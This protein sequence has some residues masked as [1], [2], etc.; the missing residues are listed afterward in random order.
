M[1]LPCVLAS[2]GALY[3]LNSCQERFCINLTMRRPLKLYYESK[4][5]TKSTTIL[6]LYKTRLCPVTRYRKTKSTWVYVLVV[7][8]IKASANK[9]AILVFAF[10]TPQH[11][12]YFGWPFAVKF[13]SRVY[14]PQDVRDEKVSS[15]LEHWEHEEIK[16]LVQSKIRWIHGKSMECHPDKTLMKNSISIPPRFCRVLHVPSVLGPNWL[17]HLGRLGG[18]S[19]LRVD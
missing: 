5:T 2:D 19:R 15:A 18:D 9:N 13:F 8:A 7:M 6:H 17:F 4:D 11:F 16:T 1:V 10:Q 14:H 3:I 12:T